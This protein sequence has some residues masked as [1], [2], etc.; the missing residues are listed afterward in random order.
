MGS[1]RHHDVGSCAIC[2]TVCH[3]NAQRHILCVYVPS[4]MLAKEFW[5]AIS[6]LTLPEYQF[7][8]LT[9][10]SGDRLLNQRCKISRSPIIWFT[11]HRAHNLWR[12][13]KCLQEVLHS[14]PSEARFASKG[15]LIESLNE[16]EPEFWRSESMPVQQF[17]AGTYNTRTRTD[18]LRRRSRTD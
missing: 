3:V 5:A 15:S 8:A 13:L 10:L 11:Q 1:V 2:K 9:K 18:F 4:R 17:K 14:C 7:T 16:A 12:D 6:N